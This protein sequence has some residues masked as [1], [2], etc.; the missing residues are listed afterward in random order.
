MLQL[1]AQTALAFATMRNV[2]AQELTSR[3]SKHGAIIGEPV[4]ATHGEKVLADGGNAVDAIVTA[5]L[6]SAVVS[7]HNC[8]IGGYGGHMTLALDGGKQVVSIDFNTTAPAAMTAETFIDSSG[9]LR[10]DAHDHGWLGAG[11]PGTLAGLQLGLGKIGTALLRA[12]RH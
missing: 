7:P 5:A 2:R 4:G 1:T 9:D 10:T 6:I 3:S 8:G 12:R 11:V